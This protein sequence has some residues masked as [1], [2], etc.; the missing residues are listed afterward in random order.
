MLEN[1]KTELNILRSL[2]MKPNYSDLARKYGIS[3]QT[4]SKYDKGFE[5]KNT[6]KRSSKLDKYLDEI[7]EKIN[8]PGATI[9]GVYK[10]FFTKDS[11]IGTRANFDY[12][13]RKNNLKEKQKSIVHPRFET[14]LGEQL[15]FDFKENITM[16]SK[17]GETF[18][19]NILTTTLGASRMHKFT[20]SKSK[21]KED[22]IKCLIESFIYYGGVLQKL[23][24]DNMSSIVNIKTKKFIENLIN[25]QK[26]LILPQKNI[27]N[28]K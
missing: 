8:L 19:F 28:V 12:Y 3:R 10:Y 4:I 22:V 25:L 27:K 11:S 6:R 17:Y 24:T 2:R 7:K 18:K 15:Q 1:I 21:T 20:Y 9:T 14:K 5:K 13:V 23:L 16:T 26:I